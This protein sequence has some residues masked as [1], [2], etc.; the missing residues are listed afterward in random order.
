MINLYLHAFCF[1]QKQFYNIYRKSM[2]KRSINNV[3]KKV[4]NVAKVPTKLKKLSTHTIQF[5]TR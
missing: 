3:R 2:Y 5:M 1:Q 4:M